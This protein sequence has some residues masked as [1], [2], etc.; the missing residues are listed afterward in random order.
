MKYP[1]PQPLPADPV[2]SRLDFYSV[3]SDLMIPIGT[4][5]AS[6]KTANLANAAGLYGVMGSLHGLTIIV[7]SVTFTCNGAT[8]TAS[9]SAMIAALNTA[10]SGAS[11]TASLN[12]VGY[13]EFTIPGASTAI[14]IGAGTANTVL[15]LTAGS[16]AYKTWESYVRNVADQ[17][18][19][20]VNFIASISRPYVNQGVAARGII[21]P[22]GGTLYCLTPWGTNQAIPL[23]AGRTPMAILAVY[24]QTTFTDGVLYA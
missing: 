7:N 17:Y 6:A 9:S 20:D 8:N 21:A 2:P 14:V 22:T 23:M 24:P 10:L 12:S 13:L 11:V 5:V 16:Y 4:P 15:G 18:F 1:Y 3:A 19:F